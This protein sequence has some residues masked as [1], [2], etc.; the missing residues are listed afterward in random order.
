MV[1]YA[2]LEPTTLY[3]IN[4]R[5]WET[6][7]LMM[8]ASQMQWL[9]QLVQHP[10]KTSLFSISLT[11]YLA[12][13]LSRSMLFDISYI[14]LI[15]LNLFLY[16]SKYYL[17]TYVVFHLFPNLYCIL[18]DKNPKRSNYLRTNL[19]IFVKPCSYECILYHYYQVLP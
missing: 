14:F 5:V 8:P 13:Y 7:T 15:I 12:S 6:W 10:L 4:G 3:W 19:T 17:D 1:G 2:G 11:V 9:S 18:V 16:L